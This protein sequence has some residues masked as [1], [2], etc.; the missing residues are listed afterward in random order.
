MSVGFVIKR[1][2]TQVGCKVHFSKQRSD[3]FVN[4]LKRKKE[5]LVFK[6]SFF[7]FLFLTIIN[8]HLRPNKNLLSSRFLKY[9]L[10]LSRVILDLN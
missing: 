1:T 6:L 2:H 9:R 4:D 7:I 5:T 8:D 10:D 3:C